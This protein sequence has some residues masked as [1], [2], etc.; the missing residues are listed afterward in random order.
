VER[1]AITNSATTSDKFSE[2]YPSE[3]VFV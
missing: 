1:T 2:F 3:G